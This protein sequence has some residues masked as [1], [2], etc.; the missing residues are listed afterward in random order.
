[1]ATRDPGQNPPANAATVST[2]KPK[3]AEA[4]AEAKLP[5]IIALRPFQ[6]GDFGKIE[7]G[8]MPEAAVK[9]I[10]QQPEVLQSMIAAGLIADQDAEQAEAAA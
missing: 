4:K 8:E 1:M 2:A 5:T 7:L 6:L 9:T 10:Y 3:A